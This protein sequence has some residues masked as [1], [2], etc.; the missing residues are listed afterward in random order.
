M[1]AIYWGNYGNSSAKQGPW[2]MADLEDGL[3]AGKDGDGWHGPG[4]PQPIS[5]GF[6]TAMVKGRP[7]GF[8]IRGGDAQDASALKLL[9]EGPRPPGYATMSKQGAIILGVGGDNS[10]R[11]V[12][13]FYE[14]AIVAGYASNATDRAV[15]A[16]IVA[17]GYQRLDER[18]ARR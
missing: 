10:N 6:V 5:A 7:G 16:D 11:A 8:A 13:T 2:V 15:H 17:A 12:G 4:T 14:G 1:E 18:P 3:W 9:Y